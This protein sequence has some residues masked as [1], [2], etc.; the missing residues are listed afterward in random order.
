M[1]LRHF[2]ELPVPIL[3]GFGGGV[4]DMIGGKEDEHKSIQNLHIKFVTAQD[5]EE[6]KT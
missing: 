1:F 3:G 5:R 2:R 4:Q 6:I